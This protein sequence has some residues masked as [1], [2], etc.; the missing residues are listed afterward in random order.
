MTGLV[1]GSGPVFHIVENRGRSLIVELGI[2]GPYLTAGAGVAV[3]FFRP[4]RGLLTV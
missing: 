3:G 4:F 2:L 1:R